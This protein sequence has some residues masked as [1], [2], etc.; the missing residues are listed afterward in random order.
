[1]EEEYKDIREYKQIWVTPET[2]QQLMLF[3]VQ[4]KAKSVDEVLKKVIKKLKNLDK[5][6]EEK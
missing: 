4:C 6:E 1:M 2:H 3:K 5:K